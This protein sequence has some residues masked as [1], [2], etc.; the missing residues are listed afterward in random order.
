MDMDV[1]LC[2]LYRLQDVEIRLPRIARMNSALQTHFGRAFG[3]GFPRA[4]GNLLERKVVTAIARSALSRGFGKSTE[5]A[6]ITADVG[7][8]DVAIDD[9]GDRVA[10]DSAPQFI[11][12]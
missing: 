4:R 6:A 5:T 1:G 7:V 12:G 2:R 9:V 10:A 8:V 3:G 11:G